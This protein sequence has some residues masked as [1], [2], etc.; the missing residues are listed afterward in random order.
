SGRTLRLDRA[1]VLAE[2]QERESVGVLERSGAH[3]PDEAVEGDPHETD[4]EEDQEDQDFHEGP[5]SPTASPPRERSESTVNAMVPSELAGMRIAA[6]QGRM[7]PATAIETAK[8][9]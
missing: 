2:W 6:S 8:V 1:G 7:K 5:P 3:G 9:L 4:S